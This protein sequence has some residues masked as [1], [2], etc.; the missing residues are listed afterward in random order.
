MNFV[1]ALIVKNLDQKQREEFDATLNSGVTDTSWANISARALDRL[2][3]GDF[4]Q[5]ER[6]G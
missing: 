1:Y 4:E 5:D 3:A 2:A 6:E